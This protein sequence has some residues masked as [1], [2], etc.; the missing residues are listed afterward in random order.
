MFKIDKVHFDSDYWDHQGV[1][2]YRG[3]YPADPTDAQKQYIW[4]YLEQFESAMQS[5]AWKE[6]YEHFIDVDSFVDYLLLQEITKNVDGYR[7]SAYFYKD[8]GQKLVAGPAWDFNI[9]FGNADY[10]S[11]PS[12][13]GWQ[14][15]NPFVKLP[16]WWPK[17]VSDTRYSTMLLRRWSRLRSSIWSDDNLKGVISNFTDVIGNAACRNY[18]KWDILD[19]KVW[20][21]PEV[22]PSF[23]AEVRSLSHW[24]V[25][26]AS[27][28][29][30]NLAGI[31]TMNKSSLLLVIGIFFGAMLFA[32]YLLYSIA[33][34]STTMLTLHLNDMGRN[35]SNCMELHALGSG[36]V[37]ES[38]GDETDLQTEE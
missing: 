1:E 6:K 35:S 31:E 15:F 17:L 4:S 2:I 32:L 33:Q 3:F 23:L 18:R 5:S 38:T 14:V 7:L 11:A 34:V 20:P 10:Y 29:D 27:W 25:H 19:R 9:A 8:R 30:D 28:M 13:E 37:M 26:R 16:F 21:E 24:I 36:G 22:H 12:T